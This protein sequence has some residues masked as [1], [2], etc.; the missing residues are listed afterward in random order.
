MVKQFYAVKV[1]NLMT[2][3]YWDV[4]Q[5]VDED[6]ARE[7]VNRTFSVFG[8]KAGAVRLATDFEVMEYRKL[9]DIGEE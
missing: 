2:R 4:V 6:D 3:D 8:G 9:V 7:Q 5:A 1:D